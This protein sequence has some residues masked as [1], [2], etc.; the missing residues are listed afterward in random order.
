MR[1]KKSVCVLATVA[2]LVGTFSIPCLA[3]GTTIEQYTSTMEEDEAVPAVAQWALL[4]TT[5][6]AISVPAG[7]YVPGASAYYVRL[8]QACLNAVGYNCG[9]AD[10]IYGTKTK[11]AIINFQRAKGIS[12]DGIVGQDTWNTLQIELHFLGTVAVF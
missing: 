12:A 1:V 3:H 7:T 9:S 10:G 11:N 4:P 6:G 5:S 2:M 8:A